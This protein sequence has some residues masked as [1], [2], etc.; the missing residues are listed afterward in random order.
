M[1]DITIGQYY[2]GD[3]VIH[4]LDPRTTLM[5]VLIFIVALFVA[6]NP[7]WYLLC[8][9]VVLALYW[10]AKVPLSYLMKGLRGIVVLLV[11]TFFFRMV[12]TPGT[13]IAQ[14]WIFTITEEG[15]ARA[16]TLTSRIALMI[17]GASLLSYTSTPRMLADGLEKAFSFLEKVHIPIHEMALIVMIAFR[18]IPIMLEEMNILMDAQA[19]RGVEFEKCSVFRKCKNI[20]SVLAPLFL[21]TVRR[22]ADLAMAMEAR[23]YSGEGPTARMYPLIYTKN[24][25]I[26]YMCIFFFL[27]VMVIGRIFN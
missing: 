5:G 6:A 20:F 26:A 15:L 18:F 9:G 2:A 14:F 7:W 1:R 16:V 10:T 12:I 8:L 21:S 19:A 13:E 23:G 3:S 11:F 24:D 25:R 22:S 27:I 17:T 4:N